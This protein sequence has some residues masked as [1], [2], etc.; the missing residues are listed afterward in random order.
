MRRWLFPALSLIF[1]A[2]VVIWWTLTEREFVLER[3]HPFHVS[4][5]NATSETMMLVHGNRSYVVR[6]GTQCAL[7]QVENN[8]PMKD[9]GGFIEYSRRGQKFTF[10]I[11]EEQTTFD[12]T[13]GHG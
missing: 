10:P 5:I 4:Q 8:Y 7:F 9:A 1:V 3:V 13:G 2:G 6:C 12:V 11:I